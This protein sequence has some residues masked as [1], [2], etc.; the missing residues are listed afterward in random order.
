MSKK[1]HC[2]ASVRYTEHSLQLIVNSGLKVSS[3]SK[4]VGAARNLVEH[5]MEK[6]CGSNLKKTVAKYS[7]QSTNCFKMSVQ[8]G[9]V[10]T[11]WLRDFSNNDDQLLQLCQI[12]RYNLDLMPDQWLLL[13]E[14]VQGCSCLSVSPFTSTDRNMLLIYVF[15]TW[16]PEWGR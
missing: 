5:F 4:A 12:L 15:H 10:L 13:E 2:W 1:G 9:T 11:K 7:F 16:Q 14:L 6:W 3:F 8:D